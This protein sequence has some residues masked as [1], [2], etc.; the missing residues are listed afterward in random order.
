[1]PSP[2][3]PCPCR[4]YERPEDEAPDALGFGSELLRS[5]VSGQVLRNGP[6]N[7]NA[8]QLESHLNEHMAL[9]DTLSSTWQQKRHTT[10]SRRPCD[11]GPR[12]GATPEAI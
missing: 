6:S 4:A 1:M 12:A 9:T 5:H 8:L 10:R 7:G 2:A 3:Q 11:K